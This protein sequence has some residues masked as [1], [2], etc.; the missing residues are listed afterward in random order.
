MDE[1]RSP[2]VAIWAVLISVWCVAPGAASSDCNHGTAVSV[3]AGKEHT[4]EILV[5]WEK[6]AWKGGAFRTHPHLPSANRRLRRHRIDPEPKPLNPQPQSAIFIAPHSNGLTHSTVWHQG[7]GF[8][9]AWSP[10]TAIGLTGRLDLQ[11]CVVGLT[12]YSQVDML[13]LRYT[14]VNFGAAKSPGVR[15]WWCQ[16][17]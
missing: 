15:N 5:R 16:T 7:Q 17:V 2:Q 14:S 12:D 3:S 8:R 4:C 10:N 6:R 1:R 9:V 11:S 13:G